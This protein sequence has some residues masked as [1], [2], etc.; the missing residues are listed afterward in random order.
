MTTGRP[1]NH[2]ELLSVGEKDEQYHK[3]WLEDNI[4]ELFQRTLGVRRWIRLRSAITVMSRFGYFAFTTLSGNPTL[5]EEYCQAQAPDKNLSKHLLMI[6]LNNELQLPKEIPKAYVSLIKDVHLITFFLF[7]DFYEFSK[8]ITNFFYLTQ[9]TTTNQTRRMSQLYKLLGCVSLI[10][11]LIKISQQAQSE[12]EF[13]TKPEINKLEDPQPA[14]D[15]AM[16][17]N[18]CS[19]T[20]AEPTSTICG[21]IFC[22]NCI[23][24]WLK[25]H[26]ECPI[27]RTPTEPSRLIHLINFR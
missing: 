14:S 19:G 15:V 3:V 27:C 26:A 16:I 6:L 12:F 7:G 17:C 23:H 1:L 9:D 20:R 24:N 18:L 10:Q 5:G 25:S 22:W 21:H 11:L 13:K 8:R 2:L 4:Q